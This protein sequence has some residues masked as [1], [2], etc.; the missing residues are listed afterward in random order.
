MS[1]RRPVSVDCEMEYE[2][3][4]GQDNRESH[5]NRSSKVLTD[6]ELQEYFESEKGT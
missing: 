5:S 4:G 1:R 2:L 6:A 3:E